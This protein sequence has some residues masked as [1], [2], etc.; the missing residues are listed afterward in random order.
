MNAPEAVPRLGI[1]TGMIVKVCTHGSSHIAV[2]N[3]GIGLPGL[4]E[5]ID[6]PVKQLLG[7]PVSQVEDP[8]AAEPVMY[9]KA[10]PEKRHVMLAGQHLPLAVPD[11]QLHFKSL[12]GGFNAGEVRPRHHGNLLDHRRG[13]QGQT[14]AQ[15][16][17]SGA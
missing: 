2:S 1:E 16:A 14:F 10:G 12:G 13:D 5:G 9:G 15:P 3:R 17:A 4:K 8:L 11:Q 6:K 7:T